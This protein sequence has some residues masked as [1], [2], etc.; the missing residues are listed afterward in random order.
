MRP[1]AGRLWLTDASLLR[2]ASSHK[3][4]AD[5][6]VVFVVK[7]DDQITTAVEDAVLTSHELSYPTEDDGVVAFVEPSAGVFAAEWVL[8][9][10]TADV[11]VCAV[12]SDGLCCGSQRCFRSV[13]FMDVT[14]PV[15]HSRETR[16]IDRA[17]VPI[18]L[19]TI[20]VRLVFPSIQKVTGCSGHGLDSLLGRVRGLLASWPCF[21]WQF[22]LLFAAA[23]KFP[24]RC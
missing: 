18:L 23:S 14:L 15:S 3:R 24:S 7:S 11:M 2:V 21:R 17:A 5:F 6:G 22:L 1:T 13:R 4:Q 10:P 12:E 8:V 16:V 19:V 9:F 20:H